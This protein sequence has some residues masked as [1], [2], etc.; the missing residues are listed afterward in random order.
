MQLAHPPGE[1]ERGPYHL[2]Q[3]LVVIYFWN[4]YQLLPQVRHIE[5][6]PPPGV[7]PFVFLCWGFWW[8]ITSAIFPW[9]AAGS[10]RK[11]STS[12]PNSGGR[13][14]LNSRK[15]SLAPLS[16][17]TP[18]PH[19]GGLC[20]GEW[21][22]LSSGKTLWHLLFCLWDLL[23]WQS[24]PWDRMWASGQPLVTDQ[25]SLSILSS[26]VAAAAKPHWWASLTL[27]RSLL[28]QVFLL[29]LL[30]VLLHNGQAAASL[31]YSSPL[32]GW[33]PF[34]LRQ[35]FKEDTMS[36]TNSS[37]C[38]GPHSGDPGSLQSLYTW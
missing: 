7:S 36:P 10:W 34:H 21:T 1:L 15:G 6:L 17:Q 27:V 13:P 30:G 4:L 25:L 26:R 32:G 28:A 18:R 37:I 14:R 23:L 31:D 3:L 8:G 16:A 2:G 9:A 35:F 38:S 20:S 22:G 11:W 29:L 19:Q 33:P 5:H 24:Q 12:G